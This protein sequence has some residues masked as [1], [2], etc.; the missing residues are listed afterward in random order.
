MEGQPNLRAVLVRGR[1]NS[2]HASSEPLPTG[3]RTASLAH[4][5]SRPLEARWSRL[6]PRAAGYCVLLW[7]LK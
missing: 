1:T 2:P 3:R 5:S 4:L 7:A 6:M